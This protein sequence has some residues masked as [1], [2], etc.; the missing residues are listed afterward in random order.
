[1]R[2]RRSQRKGTPRRPIAGFTWSGDSASDNPFFVEILTT[3]AQGV[4]IT[5]WQS[6]KGWQPPTAP[7]IMRNVQAYSGIAA[8]GDRH[9]YAFEGGVVK[10][11]VV[12]SDGSTWSLVG[13]VP[14]TI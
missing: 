9:V 13:D 2:F 5:P 7:D 6:V 10:E 14:T 11:F 12:S 3:G 4:N 8:N 1:M